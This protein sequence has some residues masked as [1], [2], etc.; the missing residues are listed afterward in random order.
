M[1]L[2][3]SESMHSF[4]SYVLLVKICDYDVHTVVEGAQVVV[5]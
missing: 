3:M 5:G 4:V 2:S 1:M